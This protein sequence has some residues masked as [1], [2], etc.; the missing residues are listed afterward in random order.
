[1]IVVSFFM[2]DCDF[3]T[4]RECFFDGIMED[5]FDFSG[6]M[7]ILAADSVYKSEIL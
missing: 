6:Y 5:C 4:F 7:K 3:N 1:M 2:W